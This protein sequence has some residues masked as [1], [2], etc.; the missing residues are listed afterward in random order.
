MDGRG[1][2]G[3][4]ERM[5]TSPGPS[6]RPVVLTLF[7]GFLLFAL[8]LTNEPP[9]F[10]YTSPS[11]P[12]FLVPTYSWIWNTLLAF[13]VVASVLGVLSATAVG[14]GRAVVG[15]GLDRFSRVC[16][17]IV[18]L[19]MLAVVPLFLIVFLAFDTI[20]FLVLEIGLFAVF[21]AVGGLSRRAKGA[22][23]R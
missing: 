10:Y 16:F 18:T 22:P 4:V 3:V 8:V 11:F 17:L 21:L 7:A 5:E 20:F 14:E 15:S 19:G 23:P 13:L 1:R 12:Y 6:A 2:R 9:I